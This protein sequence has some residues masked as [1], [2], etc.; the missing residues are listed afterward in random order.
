M[1][2]AAG[3]YPDPTGRFEHRYYD[4]AT[5][6]EFVATGGTQGNDPLPEAPAV[7]AADA[8]SA[9]TE[10][11]ARAEPTGPSGPS[12]PSAPARFLAQ[13]GWRGE[14]RAAPFLSHAL[15]AGGGAL[16][17]LGVFVLGID[18]AEDDGSGTVGALLSALLIAAATVVMLR[19]PGPVRSGCVAAL[20]IGVP[21]LW[22][23]AV[24]VQSSD[25]S[26]TAFLLLTFLSYAVLFAVPPTRGRA[27]L[28][29]LALLVLW[30]FAT[31][32]IAGTNTV[33]DLDFESSTSFE[34]GEFGEPEFGTGSD[35]GTFEEEDDFETD[36]GV[37]SLLLGA[38]Y[39]AAAWTLDRR[40]LIGA[41][42][43][44]VAVGIVAAVTGAII[45]GA[46][47][48]GV[49][50]GLL[51]VAVG[52]G[53]GYVGAR[54]NDRRASVWVGALTAVV[55]VAVVI[56]DLVDPFDSAIG[57][58]TFAI[59]VGA[60]IIAGAAFLSRW[61]GEPDDEQPEPPRPDAATT[62]PTPQGP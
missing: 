37:V 34:T 33:N 47:A 23:F 22:F 56:G 32:E 6:T 57:F 59:L 9:P 24:T 7:Q 53:V 38:G 55:G 25:G 51:A 29:G 15:G 3:W 1:G 35:V 40:R 54:G 45:V 43:P 58:A 42:T 41:A 2:Y 26:T 27:L 39:L 11:A 16:I 60:G 10:P 50:G 20:A 14:R 12:G 31:T 18:G 13:L 49:G 61:L 52:C 8:A 17:A 21:S 4:G 36:A 62:V 28:L 46:D 44:F 30:S 5:W 48:G 19:T